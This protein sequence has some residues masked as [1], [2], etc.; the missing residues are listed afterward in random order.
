MKINR[1]CAACGGRG[2]L[3]VER[4][5]RI[6]DNLRGKEYEERPCQVCRGSG[7]VAGGIPLVRVPPGAYGGGPYPEAGG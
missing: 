4:R 3:L 1:T 2:A 6:G 5:H 7:W